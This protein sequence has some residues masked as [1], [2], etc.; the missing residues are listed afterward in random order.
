MEEHQSFVDYSTGEYYKSISDGT[1]IS[2]D[3]GENSLRRKY[4]NGT[5][6]YLLNVKG[7][8]TIVLSTV[9]PSVTKSF[10][11]KL[12]QNLR[13]QILNIGIFH[14]YLEV[15]GK[16]REILEFLYISNSY[17]KYIELFFCSMRSIEVDVL[18]EFKKLNLVVLLDRSIISSF[19][20]NKALAN[21]VKTGWS[22]IFDL[23]QFKPYKSFFI[24]SNLKDQVLDQYFSK[25]ILYD[26]DKTLN[27]RIK[28]ILPQVKKKLPQ[29]IEI[30]LYNSFE[31]NMKNIK[32][33]L[34]DL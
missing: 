24:H 13:T 2:F 18:N 21:S 10:L 16:F 19:I 28:G 31:E 32:S 4:I 8:P 11:C 7:K 27:Y 33:H 26:Q 1:V 3:S 29:L 20:Y 5:L 23:S 22:D 9:D 12:P 25:D 6:L 34:E 15:L 17:R 14:L 30:E